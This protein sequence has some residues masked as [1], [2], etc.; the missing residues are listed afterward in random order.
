[1]T[2]P[3][4]K[5]ALAPA[6]GLAEVAALAG[7]FLVI[8][9]GI[10]PHVA[11]SPAAMAAY[12][13]VVAAWTAMI[14]W[15]SPVLLHRDPAGLRGWGRGRSPDDPGATRNAWPSYLLLTLVAA[16]ILIAAGLIRDPHLLT[17]THWGTV[18][19]KLVIYL[20][21]GPLQALVFFG[22]LQTRIRTAIAPMVAGARTGQALTVLATSGLFAAAHA[23]NWLLASLV[24]GMGLAWSWLFYRRP[25]VLLT[26]VSHAVL[27]TIIYS[28]LKIFTRIGPFYA[29]PEGHIVRNAIPGLKALVGDLF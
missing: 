6:W 5:P 10:G 20:V 18:G 19:H 23:P 25:N 13:I 26:G 4:P 24:L 8:L 1:M 29:H 11:D 7:C 2:L 17:R 27:G 9:W 21:F 22:Y 14:A 3:P 16:F 12:W 15:I 28:V